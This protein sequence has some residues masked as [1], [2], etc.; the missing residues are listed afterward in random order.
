[1][2][3]IICIAIIFS[4]CGLSLSA[5]MNKDYVPCND[6]PNIMQNY[7]AD[8]M[9]LDRVYILEGSPEIRERYKKVANDYLD[10]LEKIN[11]NSLPQGCKADYILFKR[12]LKE[13][14]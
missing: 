8:I 12:D 5:Q 6:M 9:A 11:F 7:H 2:R 14:V 10:R 13:A 1:M 3:T 4:F